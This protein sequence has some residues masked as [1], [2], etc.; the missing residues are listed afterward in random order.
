MKESVIQKSIMDYL[1]LYQQNND[2]YFFRSGAGAI[3]TVMGGYF[4]TGK[5]GCPDIV[6]CVPDW[7]GIGLFLG[8][9]VKTKTGRQSENQ[10]AAE[11]QIIKAGGQYHIVRSISDVK[12][13][14]SCLS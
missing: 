11:K 8:L 10:K 7:H 12:K 3:K 9:E 5:K 6:V 1:A 13:V 4:K 14:L 2:I